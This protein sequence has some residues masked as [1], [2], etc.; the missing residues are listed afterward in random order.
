MRWLA[1]LP[2]ALRLRAGYRGYLDCALEPRTQAL[3]YQLR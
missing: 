1:L 3:G 2:L